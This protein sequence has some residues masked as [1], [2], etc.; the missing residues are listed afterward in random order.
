M[1]DR[2]P[3]GD[4]DDLYSE[5]E[6]FTIVVVVTTDTPEKVDHLVS[7]LET[8]SDGWGVTLQSID[9]EQDD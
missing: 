3:H 9:V 5:Q 1:I 6:E 8:M 7:D 2:F 4:Y